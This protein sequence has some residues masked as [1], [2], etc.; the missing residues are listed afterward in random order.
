MNGATTNSPVLAAFTRVREAAEAYMNER[1]RAGLGW[2][3]ETVTD[4]STHKGLPEVKVI[5]FTRNQQGGGVGAD[6]LWQWLDRSTEECFGMLVQAKRLHR[7][8]AAGQSTSDTATA[9]STPTCWPQPPSSRCPRSMPFTPAARSSVMVFRASTTSCPTASAA[10]A[11]LSRSS[12]PTSSRSSSPRAR[13]PASSSTTRSA[14]GP[15]RPGSHH[16]PVWYDVNLRE[17]GP[18][19]LRDFLLE[20]QTGPREIAKPIFAA[21][22]KQRTL[23]F[24]AAAAEP[25]TVPGAPVFP[26]V[27]E[28]RGHYPGPYYRHVLQGLRTSPPTYIVDLQAGLPPSPELVDRVAGVVLITL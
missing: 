18:G 16:Q 6:Y 4:I 10:G 17:L 5:P 8:G 13:R 20:N 9:S 3:E 25:I 22:A 7:R 23:A 14:R 27:P 1:D 19:D 21:V 2:A 26:H 28:D 15:R 24:S 11:W 12:A